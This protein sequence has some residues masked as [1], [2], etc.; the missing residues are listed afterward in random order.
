MTKENIIYEEGVNYFPDMN[1]L[2]FTDMHLNSATPSSR[3]D[4]YLKSLFEK[5]EWLFQLAIETNS[6]IICGGD[7][8]HTPSQ[9][10]LV[11]NRLMALVDKY[12]VIVFSIIGNHDL[13][14]YNLDFLEK[15]TLGVMFNS[16]HI[17]HLH[18]IKIG[19][20][21]FVAHE[22]GD[23]FPVVDRETIIISHCFYATSLSDKLSVSSEDVKNSNAAMVFMGHDHNMYNPVENNG[24]IVLRPGALSR[25][26]SA[27]ENRVRQ[28]S[29]ASVNMKTGKV[30][31]VPCPV[32]KDFNDVFRIKV[33]DKPKEVI[34]FDQIEQF[35]A[36]LKN[37]DVRNNPYDI[38]MGMG[39]SKEVYD[40][41]AN[42]MHNEGLVP[43]SEIDKTF[44]G[45]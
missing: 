38:L 7:L 10:D 5:L 1:M 15:T 19:G 43:E 12:K 21:K 39:V 33:E 16:G 45:T 9:P 34:T 25:G 29:I 40:C 28:L 22:F 44:D 2:F 24:T 36:K 26:S 42:Y 30:E 14:Y 41:A 23:A 18:H 35:I 13:L 8:F 37:T 4:D 31:Y 6:V 17:K 3:I 11:K 27:T 20:Y 32:V